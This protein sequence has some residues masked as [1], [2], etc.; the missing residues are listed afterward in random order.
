[1][2][3]AVLDW[4]R[5]YCC[6]RLCLRCNCLD[7]IIVME[8]PTSVSTLPSLCYKCCCLAAS[9][10]DVCDEQ[11]CQE[12]GRRGFNPLSTKDHQLSIFSH[13]DRHVRPTILIIH[14]RHPLSLMQHFMILPGREEGVLGA[15]KPPLFL[16][17][18]SPHMTN[19][20]R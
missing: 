4:S 6:R 17:S 13:T 5:H 20:P 15:E 14:I 16:F 2:L 19:N 3:S 1:M 8:S 11:N 12:S 18:R 7:A 10:M 9:I